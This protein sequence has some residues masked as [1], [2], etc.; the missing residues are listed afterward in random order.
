MIHKKESVVNKSMKTA[1]SFDPD[2][3]IEKNPSRTFSA[4][5]SFQ[6]PASVSIIWKS[7]DTIVG[8]LKYIRDC[9]SA[10]NSVPIV[11]F[12]LQRKRNLANVQRCR[13]I[14][15]SKQSSDKLRAMNVSCNFSFIF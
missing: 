3:S 6:F 5:A 14:C 7:D 9:K 12:L 15:I 13:V 2:M 11:K 4:T 8:A 1:A 10:E